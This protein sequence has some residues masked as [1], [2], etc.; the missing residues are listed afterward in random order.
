LSGTLDL[1]LSGDTGEF[2]TAEA[3]IALHRFHVAARGLRF[4]NGRASG[5]VALGFDYRIDYPMVIHYPVAGLPERRVPLTFEGPL[6]AELRLAGAGAGGAGTVEG[7]YSF[8]VPW[9]PIEK[10][11]LE[12]LRAKWTQDVSPI[13]NV[14]FS[15]EPM[16]FTPCGGSCFLSKFRFIAEKG[17]VRHRLFR[18]ICEPEGKAELFIDQKERSF[19]LR[20]VVV[21]T[22]CEG[23]LGWF[24]NRIA[25][26]FAKSYDDVTLFRIPAG[27]PFSI[28]VVRSGIDWIEISGGIDWAGTRVA[29]APPVNGGL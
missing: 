26:F 29:P 7:K 11:A 16:R 25:P 4:V 28:D 8:K 10:A 14:K 3:R 20:K 22:H 13:R 17:D 19:Q 5:D 27:V 15:V 18:Q 21:E 9:P 2:A 12:V 24:A 1:D 6:T 23:V